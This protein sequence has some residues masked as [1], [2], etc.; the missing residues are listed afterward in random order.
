MVH[1]ASRE[2]SFT[3]TE[4]QEQAQAL[5]HIDLYFSNFPIDMLQGLQ[6][7]VTHELNLHAENTSKELVKV[8]TNNVALHLDYSRVTM[9]REKVSQKIERMQQEFRQV[10]KELPKVPMEVETLIEQQVSNIDKVIQGF[11]SNI[12]ELESC[13]IPGTPPEEIDQRENMVNTSVENIKIL[14]AECAKLCEENTK[15]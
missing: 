5:S 4:M 12:I 7:S 1:I 10:Y 14:E 6:V 13:A 9:E 11:R 2:I 15:V 3:S 8:T